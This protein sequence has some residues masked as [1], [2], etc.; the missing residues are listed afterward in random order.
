MRFIKYYM[1]EDVNYKIYCDMDGCITDFVEQYTKYSGVTPEDAEYLYNNDMEKF[2]EPVNKGGVEFW[3]EMPWTEDGKELW[4]YISPMNPTILTAPSKGDDCPTG[5]KIWIKRELGDIPTLIERDKYKYSGENNIL[6]D[7]TK[8]KID[9]WIDAGGIG[10]L[11]V[12]TKD[13]INKLKGIMG[14]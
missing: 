14:E 2:W 9:D 5:K 4:E 3:S 10:I 7:D 8:K 13:T 6:I 11:H 12:S 1:N